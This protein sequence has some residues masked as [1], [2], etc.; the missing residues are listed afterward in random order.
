MANRHWLVLRNGT[1]RIV[2]LRWHADNMPLSGGT[3][4]F[5]PA[6]EG[7]GDVGGK[8]RSR[9]PRYA[10]PILEGLQHAGHLDGRGQ[11]RGHH[12]LN[13]QYNGANWQKRENVSLACIH[14]TQVFYS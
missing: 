3:H 9:K 13:R 8:C 7:A 1:R 14:R 4:Q 6:N 10:G 11:G 5:V 12:Q 2:D